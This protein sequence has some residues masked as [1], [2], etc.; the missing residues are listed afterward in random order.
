MSPTS[1]VFAQQAPSAD[2]GQPPASAV[3]APKP[4]MVGGAK[5]FSGEE[6]APAEGQ[7]TGRAATTPTS[8]A[9]APAPGKR[10]E[11][12]D[13]ATVTEDGDCGAAV[14]N[15]AVGDAAAGGVTSRGPRAERPPGWPE[16]LP[17]PITDPPPACIRL[18]GPRGMLIYTLVPNQARMWNKILNQPPA[19][20]TLP[21][22]PVRH[23]PIVH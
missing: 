9:V 16:P 17:W 11:E 5:S 22:A 3:P 14:A 4:V 1:K 8:P 21:V 23:Q 2:A 15:G 12:S 18:P 13:G 19:Q 6:A 10:L 20:C 7:P